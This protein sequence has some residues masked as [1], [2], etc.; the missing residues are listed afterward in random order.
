MADR[1]L[2][3]FS[4]ELMQLLVAGSKRR[5]VVRVPTQAK[6][7]S[8]RY[9]FYHLRKK[10][11]LAGQPH[12]QHLLRTQAI[13]YLDDIMWNPALKIKPLARHGAKWEV[14]VEPAD[15]DLRNNILEALS[16][17]AADL[18]EYQEVPDYPAE[19]DLSQL[20]EDIPADSEPPDDDEA[21][22]LTNLPEPKVENK[23]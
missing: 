6:A 17:Q 22:T 7:V 13:I 21:I 5:I 9:R 19:P 1:T 8:L 2:E 12:Q 23:S 18:P 15:S 14:V 16:S 3:Q 11:K 10:I 20:I 4:D